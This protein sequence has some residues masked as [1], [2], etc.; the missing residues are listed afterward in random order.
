MSELLGYL[1]R[2]KVRPDADDLTEGERR[3]LNEHFDAR[4]AEVIVNGEPLSWQEIDEVEVVRAARMGGP[5]GW[6]VRFMYG[7]DRYHV[8]I[9]FG[10]NEIVLPNISLKAATHV[11]QTIAFYAPNPIRYRGLEGI[12]A[13]EE[14]A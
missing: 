8:G 3:Y 9:Y 6:M 4:A 2:L 7:Q 14:S 10:R 5:A 1:K 12:S 11:V 13:I